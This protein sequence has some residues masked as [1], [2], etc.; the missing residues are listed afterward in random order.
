M[1]SALER[2]Y[3]IMAFDICCRKMKTCTRELIVLMSEGCC[4]EMEYLVLV[5]L[6]DSAYVV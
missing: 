5:L 6:S 2:S 3:E 4:Y 1:S